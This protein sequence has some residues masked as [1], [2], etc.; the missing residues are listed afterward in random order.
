MLEEIYP[1][2]LS[3]V[4]A[5]ASPDL[6]VDQR[7]A[8]A[9]C[10]NGEC[11]NESYGSL[12]K[13]HYAQHPSSNL[14]LLLGSYLLPSS[15]CDFSQAL[16]TA[17]TIGAALDLIP[18]Y[19]YAQG[20]SYYPFISKHERSVRICMLFPK[21]KGISEVQRRYC[22]ETALSYLANAFLENISTTI[23]PKSLWFDFSKPAYSEQYKMRFGRSG[24]FD[25]AMTVVEFDA[26]ALDIPLNTHNPTLHSLYLKKYLEFAHD[27]D[28]AEGFHHKVIA[29]LLLEH[30]ESMNSQDLANRLNISVRGLQKRLSKFDLSFSAIANDCRRE[31]SKVYLLCENRGTDATAELLGFQSTSGFRRFFRSEFDMTPCDYIAQQKNLAQRFNPSQDSCANNHIDALSH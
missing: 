17:P 5:T 18:R 3:E 27:C 21:R 9:S 23:C 25:Q 16:R 20:A 15:L 4:I 6:H 22:A 29:T 26:S 13:A 2:L 24:L 1:R 7:R 11:R 10:K 12:V 19:Y 31:L 14:G 28:R 30:P 8:L